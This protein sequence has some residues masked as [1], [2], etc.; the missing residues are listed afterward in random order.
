MTRPS[1]DASD[2]RIY[3]A[4]THPSSRRA[5]R[6][7]ARHHRLDKQRHH[8]YLTRSIVHA[9]V[10][11][12]P[13]A[14]MRP[15]PLM[16]TLTLASVTTF[17]FACVVHAVAFVS[18]RVPRARRTRA[19]SRSMA[20]T[21]TLAAARGVVALRKLPAIAVRAVSSTVYIFV[22]AH[23]SSVARSR[24]SSPL[25]ARAIVPRVSRPRDYP[26]SPIVRGRRRRA[27]D[28]R[29][30]GRRARSNA[31]LARCSR[32]GER[33]RTLTAADMGCE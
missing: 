3:D 32:R 28:R 30:R 17:T 1:S 20:H 24:S 15:K 25:A 16:A 26:R 18:L 7:R 33:V 31:R 12:S 10:F 8:P 14:P 5:R 29:R 19:R 13:H 11:R 9:R 23:P 22:H 21:R 6:R 27:F 4:S 2:E